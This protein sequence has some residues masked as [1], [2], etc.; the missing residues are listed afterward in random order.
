MNDISFTIEQVTRENYHLFDDMVYWRVNGKERTEEKEV[1][2]HKIYEYAFDE[3]LHKDFKVYAALYNGR[4]IGWISCVY[5]PKVGYWKKGYI[6]IDELWT[7]PEFRRKGVATALI[8]K[9]F[10]L[11]KEMGAVSL[12]LYTQDDNTTAQSLY[13]RCGFKIK[14]KAVFMEAE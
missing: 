8:Q 7:A 12:R 9:A 2:K 6:Y 11:Q 5:I 13:K 14:G 4:F 3:L 1:S 10:E